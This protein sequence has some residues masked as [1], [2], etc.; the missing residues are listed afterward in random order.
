MHLALYGSVAPSSPIAFAT[1]VR[2]WRVASSAVLVAGNIQDVRHPNTR[3][4][5]MFLV[6]MLENPSHVSY[7]HQTKNNLPGDTFVVF[8]FQSSRWK[9]F[10]ERPTRYKK[11]AFFQFQV[12][13]E[14]GYITS[15]D[16]HGFRPLLGSLLGTRRLSRYVSLALP[17]AVRRDRSEAL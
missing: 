7:S 3:W 1:T 14:V 9:N 15:F 6:Q 16:P 11:D 10:Q 17:S 12:M 5:V 4:H 13:H 2:Y 8:R